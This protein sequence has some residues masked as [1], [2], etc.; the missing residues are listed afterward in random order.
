MSD[1][2]KTRAGDEGQGQ[3]PG[4]G[5]DY[6]AIQKSRADNQRGRASVEDEKARLAAQRRARLD[7]RSSMQ[8]WKDTLNKPKAWAC[9]LA[10]AALVA[11]ALVMV[12][13]ISSALNPPLSL[14]QL[15]EQSASLSL[16]A[17][18]RLGAPAPAPL[19][20]ESADSFK[21][22]YLTNKNQLD[23]SGKRIG[24]KCKV[25]LLVDRLSQAP[26]LKVEASGGC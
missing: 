5:D 4:Q 6:A 12:P 13:K 20:S 17:E 19:I 16:Q 14:G 7:R 9:V 3:V 1:A 11:L 21:L 8:R 15:Q 25:I 10:A 22:V 2:W 23:F 26:K 18:R 24:K